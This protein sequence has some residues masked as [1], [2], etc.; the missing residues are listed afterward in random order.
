MANPQK[1]EFVDE[2]LR[3]NRSCLELMEKLPEIEGAY[4]DKTWNSGGGDEIVDADV[5]DRSVTASDIG[6]FITMAQQ[7]NKFFSNQ[8]V[9]Q[10][11]YASTVNKLRYGNNK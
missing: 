1:T 2:V 10:G 4:F 7:L 3:L 8:A 11:D 9:T 6:S 5:S